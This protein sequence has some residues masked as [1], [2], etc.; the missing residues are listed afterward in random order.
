[1]FSANDSDSYKNKFIKE[2]E[3]YWIKT[4]KTPFPLGLNDNIFHVGNL[5]RLPNF[6]IFTLFNRKLRNKR[7]HGKRK[8][9]NVRRRNRKNLTLADCHKIF[10]NSGRHTLLSTLSN[11]P[12]TTLRNLEEESDMIFFRTNPL[13]EV[14]NIIQIYALHKLR[15]HIDKEEDHI[16]RRIKLNFI[17]KGID[18][19]N[20]PSI[21]NN[22]NITEVIPKYFKNREPPIICYKYTKPVRNLIF[23]YNKTVSD[24]DILGNKPDSCTCVDSNYK[25]EPVGHVITGDF[26]LLEDSILIDIFNKG[27]K[28]RLPVEVNFEDCLFEISNAIDTFIKNWCKREG[29]KE[30]ALY[31]WKSRILFK[32]SNTIEFYKTNLHLLPDKPFCNIDMLKDK[33]NNIHNTFVLVP[34]DK[35]ANNIIII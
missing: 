34:A 22:K 21:F 14:C 8:N 12:V 28:Y 10:T 24:V 9:N 17:N 35:A 1:V 20:L 16:R 6:D 23:N 13:Y 18:I 15:P 3:L 27:P 11:L 5:S 33:L 19:I 31:S 2:R 4:L 32:I 30:E 29:A 25:Y 7:S 26:H